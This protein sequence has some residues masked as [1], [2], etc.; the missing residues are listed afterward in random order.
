MKINRILLFGILLFS[1]DSS[2]LAQGQPASNQLPGSMV[3]PFRKSPL[4]I[5]P[6]IGNSLDG[7]WIDVKY[8][9]HSVFPEPS[10]AAI[11]ITTA[12]GNLLQETNRFRILPQERRG[13][14]TYE[15][16]SSEADLQQ[17]L[18]HNPDIFQA[19]YAFLA[20]LQ[21]LDV[22]VNYSNQYGIEIEKVVVN[23]RFSLRIIDLH[24]H[25]NWQIVDTTDQNFFHERFRTEA[26][27]A[28]EVKRQQD[29]YPDSQFKVI[30]PPPRK[31]GELV[32]ARNVEFR[33]AE[34]YVV[35]V[36]NYYGRDIVLVREELVQNAM[37][38]ALE[39]AIIK[40]M[41][42]RWPLRGIKVDQVAQQLTLNRGGWMI[43]RAGLRAGF[44]RVRD[45][46]L[47]D[48]VRIAPPS[49][50][51]V[52]EPGELVRDPDNG[53]LLG[54]KLGTQLAVLK[55]NAANVEDNFSTADI[56]RGRLSDADLPNAL[57]RPISIKL[58]QDDVER[59]K[60]SRIKD[61]KYFVVTAYGVELTSAWFRNIPKAPK[62]RGR[63]PRGA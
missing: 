57:I 17:T 9:G 43:S 3:I 55:V 62:T 54:R 23:V 39:T 63:R 61:M 51:G 10:Q 40:W 21:T 22:G 26:E 12:F 25:K 36:G 53:I 49:L 60:F 11:G 29:L 31:P 48:K 2:V 34:A 24:P 28:E 1:L 14:L 37:S 8:G 7:G 15:M 6:T 50:F 5:V 13:L 30:A 33:L 27:A 52:Y 16:F 47:V 58:I 44:P 42:G 4:I 46:K 18:E 38:L 20:S 41:E 56:L 35:R 59:Q 19:D 45:G 32:W